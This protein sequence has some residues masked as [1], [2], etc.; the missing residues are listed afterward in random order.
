M[1]RIIFSIIS[2]LIS[3]HYLIAQDH[4]IVKLSLQE[5][6]QTA[7]DKNVDIQTAILDQQKSEYKVKESRSVLLPQIDVNGNIT[8]N[9]QLPVTIIPG[10]FLGK[11][12]SNYSIAMGSTYN[13]SPNITIR[14]ELYNQ[15]K[16]TALKLSNKENALQHMQT[17][18]TKENLVYDIAKLYFSALTT[19]KQKQLDEEN[20]ARTQ[21]LKEITLA[22]VKSGINKEVDYDRVC[23]NLENLHTDLSNTEATLEQQQNM[24]KYMLGLSLDTRLSLTDSIEMPFF[25]SIPPLITD[26]NNHTDIKILEAQK[27]ISLLTQKKIANGY[28]P[29]LSFTGQFEYLGLRQNFSNYF[30][31]STENNW[32]PSSYIGINLSIPVFDGMG[33]NAQL[34]QSKVDYKENV[35]KLENTKEKYSADYKNAVNNFQNQQEN[36]KRQKD[37]VALAEKIYQETTLQYRQGEVAISTL[38]QDEMDMNNAQASYIKALYDLKIS[39]LDMVS[40]NGDL[41]KL[42]N[43]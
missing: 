32:Y 34:R 29:T 40:L 31:N 35:L 41:K 19:G 3:A 36:V 42:I 11:P 17:Q 30:R 15:T 33:K 20:L 4:A 26:F 27:E 10:S 7:L 6:L 23:V 9:L 18:K 43:K 22:L 28:L 1:R 37:N 13:V 25:A 16:L 14:Q 5:C 2:I 12:G 8:D 24:I 38:L 21:Q 39:I